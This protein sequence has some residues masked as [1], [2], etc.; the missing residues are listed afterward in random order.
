VSAPLY[1]GLLLFHLG[2]R[3]GAERQFKAVLDPDPNNAAASAYMALLALQRSDEAKARTFGARAV[4]AGRQMPI[5]HLANGLAL[6]ESKQVEPAKRSLRDALAL[7]PSLLSAEA[8][9][10]EMELATNRESA[11]GRLVK[12]AGLD[13]AYLIAKRLLFITDQRG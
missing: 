10:A 3:A 12:V 7:A 1:E 13:P 2:E 8:K 11:R 4:A 5:T 9:L 6:A